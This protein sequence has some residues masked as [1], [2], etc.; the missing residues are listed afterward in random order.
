M[1]ESNYDVCTSVMG[2]HFVASKVCA[3]G[4]YGYSLND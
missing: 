2:L 4:D 1:S 3:V